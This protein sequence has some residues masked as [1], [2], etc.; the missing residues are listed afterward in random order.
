MAV[1]IFHL[2]R[3]TGPSPLDRDELIRNREALVMLLLSVT[4]QFPSHEGALVARA[5]SLVERLDGEYERAY[6]TGLVAERRARALVGHGGPGATLSAGDWLRDAMRH[7][8]RAEAIRPA[9]NDDARL[10]WNACARLVM[11]HPHL[12]APAGDEYQPLMLE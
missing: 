8:E 3:P 9:G 2:S 7:F 5:Q 12:G 1:V 10:R 4:D 11:R 6:Y